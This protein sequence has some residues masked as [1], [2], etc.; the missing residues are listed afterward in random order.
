MFEVSCGNSDLMSVEGEGV[1]LAEAKLLFFSLREINRIE[2][3]EEHVLYEHSDRNYSFDEI[4]NLVK[5]PFDQFQDTTDKNFRG[6]RFYW[7]TKDV[8]EKRV[9]LVI[10]FARDEK[11]QLILVVSAGERK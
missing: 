8:N 5:N 6:N 9:R 4:L 2:V 11:G 3:C 1:N 10:E 7:R